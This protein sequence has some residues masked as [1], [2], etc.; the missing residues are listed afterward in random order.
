MGKAAKGTVLQI[1]SSAATPVYSS[2]SEVRDISGGGLTADMVDLTHHDSD[3]EEVYPTILRTQELTF[4]LN[5][6][7]RHAT[8]GATGF[9]AIRK[10]VL[11]RL[12][13][14]VK[15]ITPA[16]TSTAADVIVLTGFFTGFSLS[17][18]VADGLFADCT[19]KPIGPTF[20]DYTTLAAIP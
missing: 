4:Q 3:V 20:A 8:H 10:A 16:A 2:I 13:R 14:S 12:E 17:M 11:D 9:T 1:A 7:P 19:F 5:W 15:I 6:N 18:A